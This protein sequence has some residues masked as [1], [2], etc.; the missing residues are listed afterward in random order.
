MALLE[1]C[2][3][4]LVNLDK[5]F[6]AVDWHPKARK[7]SRWKEGTNGWVGLDVDDGQLRRDWQDGKGERE[8]RLEL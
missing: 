4:V 5:R 3:L 7:A 6:K 8:V 2:E 1:R